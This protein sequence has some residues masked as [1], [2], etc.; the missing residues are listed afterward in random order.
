M[1][2]L[3]L[4]PS[5]V[6]GSV[7]YDELYILFAIPHQCTGA[8]ICPEGMVF[9]TKCLPCGGTINCANPN[10]IICPLVCKIGCACA[11]GTILNEETGQCV[12]KCP[13]NC[14]IKGQVYKRCVLCPRNPFT[15]DSPSH[16]CTKDCRP[17]CECPYGKVLDQKRNKCVPLDKCL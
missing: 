8:D 2:S 15:C 12:K 6:C 10:P 5:C 11:E 1:V 7:S 13:K 14:P 9:F 16:S 17:G 3:K 4:Y